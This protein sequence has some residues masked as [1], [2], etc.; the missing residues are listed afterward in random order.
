M[1]LLVNELLQVLR[2]TQRQGAVPST[3]KHLRR[4]AAGGQQQ[5]SRRPLSACI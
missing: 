4:A 2:Y 5:V 1:L 3:I